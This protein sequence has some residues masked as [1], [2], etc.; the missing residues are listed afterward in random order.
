MSMHE[1]LAKR[2][3]RYCYGQLIG[4]MYNDYQDN[5]YEDDSYDDF[6]F[7]EEKI[8]NYIYENACYEC[9]EI[10]FAT[11]DFC[12]NYINKLWN[13]DEDRIELEEYFKKRGKLKRQ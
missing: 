9:K 5:N 6:I 8:K 10:K 11:K 3:I 13:S 1:K 12:M 4:G 2:V 7:D